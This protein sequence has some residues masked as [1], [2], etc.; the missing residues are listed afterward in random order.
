[1]VISGAAGGLGRALSIR[2]GLLG[3]RVGIIDREEDALGRLSQELTA[4]GITNT[5]VTLD[6]TKEKAC[7]RALDSISAKFG[8]V[9]VLVNNAGIT[10]RSAFVKTRSQVFRRVMDVNFFGSL[11]LTRAALPYL[12]ASR[13]Q[14]IV[15]SSIAGF[16]PLLGRPGYAASKHALQGFFSS[17]RPELSPCGITITIACPGFTKTGINKNALDWDGSKTLHPQS[18]LGKVAEPWETAGVIIKGAMNNRPLVIHSTIGRIT[19]LMVKIAPR[20]YERMMARSLRSELDRH[21]NP[22][23]P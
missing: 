12:I 21:D 16:A 10:H 17:L 2:F 19:Y 6:I 18:T 9:Y 4:R 7:G 5:P 23:W 13:G 1:V 20:L 3:A 14:I 8:G 22:G 11:Y 15:V